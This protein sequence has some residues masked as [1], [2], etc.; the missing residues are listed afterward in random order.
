MTVNLVSQSQ[1]KQ[2]FPQ[3]ALPPRSWTECLLDESSNFQFSTGGKTRTKQLN[4]QDLCGTFTVGK[5]GANGSHGEY[6]QVKT[7]II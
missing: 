5:L 7:T 4:L 1:M 2:T 6:F 3:P